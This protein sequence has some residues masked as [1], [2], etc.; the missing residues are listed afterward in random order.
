MIQRPGKSIL[1]GLAGLQADGQAL[2]C[3]PV[4]APVSPISGQEPARTPQRQMHT[5]A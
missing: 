4:L 1:P 3:P 5:L 2:I